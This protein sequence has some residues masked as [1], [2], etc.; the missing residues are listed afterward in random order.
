MFIVFLL[1][2][3]QSFAGDDTFATVSHEMTAFVTESVMIQET[4]IIEQTAAVETIQASST[5][6]AESSN[7]NMA[8]VATV[9]SNIVPTPQLRAV[10]VNPDDMGD[11]RE[12]DMMD[13]E[14]DGSTS[15]IS[16]E[17]LINN[18]GTARSVSSSNGCSNGNVT[19]FTDADDRIYT[20]ARVN[21]LVSGINFSVDWVFEERLVYRSSWT[22]D[23]SASS[24]CLWFFMTQDDAPFLPGLYTITMF[25]N[26]QAQPSQQFSI[27]TN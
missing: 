18:L 22:S 25:V 9:E 20:T 6:I 23:Y 12:G 5:L 8:L 16:G 2:G 24:E 7:I 14:F 11:S 21:N 1:V 19:Q 17:V 15:E 3:C 10:I 27:S 13:D 26:G 4:A